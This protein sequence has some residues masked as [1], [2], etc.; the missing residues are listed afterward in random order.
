MI[1][2]SKNIENKAYKYAWTFMSVALSPQS[3]CDA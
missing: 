3:I 1:E 2:N